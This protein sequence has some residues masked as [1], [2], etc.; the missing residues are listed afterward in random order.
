M[1]DLEAVQNHFVMKEIE[2]LRKLSDN[3]LNETRTLERFALVLTGVIWSW[4]ATNFGLTKTVILIWFP[5][6]AT[7][8]FGIR[9][10]GMYRYSL[11]IKK[12][13]LDAERHYQLPEHFGWEKIE[14]RFGP[15]LRVITS[16]MF[17]VVLQATTIVVPTLHHMGM[18]R[19]LKT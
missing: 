14:G 7:F 4:C 6:L 5:A 2:H 9:A 8:L 10:F 11:G 3:A 16:Y 12:Y 13:I 18:I 17:W 19:I 15:E 1:P